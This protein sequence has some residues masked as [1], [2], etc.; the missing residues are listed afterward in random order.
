[1]S[2]GKIN[3]LSIK[4]KINSLL[5]TIVDNVNDLFGE[6]NVSI[7]FNFPVYMSADDSENYYWG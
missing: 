6:M 2:K 5:V 1:M 7:V 3:V 4:S